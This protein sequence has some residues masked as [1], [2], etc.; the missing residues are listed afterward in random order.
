MSPPISDKSIR[1]QKVKTGTH[2][3]LRSTSNPANLTIRLLA[4]G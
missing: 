1:F 3:S 4:E 2:T